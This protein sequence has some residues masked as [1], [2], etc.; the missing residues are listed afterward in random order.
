VHRIA[1]TLKSTSATF[2]M[3]AVSA[4]ARKLEVRARD[5]ILDGAG[6]MIRRVEVEYLRA[7]PLLEKEASKRS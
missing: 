2:G 5:G 4:V 6:E 1:H 3:M 7:K